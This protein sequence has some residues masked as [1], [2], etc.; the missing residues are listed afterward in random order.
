MP[1]ITIETSGDFRRTDRFLDFILKRDIYRALDSYGRQ[2]VESLSQA[3]PVGPTGV[4]S[5]SWDYEVVRD[6]QGWSIFWTN[7]DTEDGFS[8]VIGLQYGHG[9]GTGGWVQGRDFIN[10]AI[11]PIMDRIAEDVWKAVTTA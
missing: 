3:T 5:T 9:T 6:R 1:V 2:G 8:V 7:D 11:K 10:P 4:A